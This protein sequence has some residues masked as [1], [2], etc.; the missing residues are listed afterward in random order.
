M[1]D[2]GGNPTDIYDGEGIQRIYDGGGPKWRRWGAGSQSKSSVVWI[3]NTVCTLA[4]LRAH[5]PTVLHSMHLEP[6]HLV[7][8]QY[9]LY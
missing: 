9:Y 3:Y 7:D 8:P 6:T 5:S 4:A 1:D 2:G